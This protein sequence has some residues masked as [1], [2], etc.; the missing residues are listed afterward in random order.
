M[1]TIERDYSPKGVKFFYVYKALA[2]PEYDGYVK[3][4]TLEER[5]LHLKEA[6]RRLGSRI[7]WLADNMGNGL[8]HLM[9]GM[10]NSEVIIDPNGQV[11]RRRQWSDPAALR[12]D[13]TRL[14]GPVDKPTRVE[15]LDMPTKPPPTTVAKGIVPRVK[16]PPVMRALKLEP[17][18]SSKPYYVK[19]R[20]EVEP[21]FFKSGKSKMYIGFHLDPLYRVHWNNLTDPLSFE[22]DAPEGVEVTPAV[23]NAPK[24][25]E[26]ADA[27]PRE[28]MVRLTAKNRD[29]P[30]ALRV[31]Y[32][33][34]DDDDTFCVL[35]EQSYTIEL[36]RDPDG[37]GA[38]GRWMARGGG[39]MVERIM[40][41]DANGDGRISRDEAPA[42]M[43]Q[44]M[45]DRM[46]GDGDGYVTRAEIEAAIEQMRQLRGPAR[47]QKPTKK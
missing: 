11:V 18:T 46:D 21:R 19:L 43:R 1:E 26:E 44:G 45:F 28:F 33:A 8:K 4:F 25:K 38:P 32:Y 5:L 12:R 42:R 9:G 22:I 10:P 15:D 37:G 29:K 30:L 14:I 16:T 7:P 23:G 36:E 2:H 40:K 24:V 13:L 41:R 35:V 34:C 20:A 27:D 47:R 31:K 17:G 39:N 6:E 3:A